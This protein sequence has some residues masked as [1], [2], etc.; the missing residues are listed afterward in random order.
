VEGTDFARLVGCF[1]R[2]FGS[3][4]PHDIPAASHDSVAGWDSIAQVTLLS[5]VGEEF[6]IEIDFEEFEEAT[7]FDAILEVVRARSGN[8]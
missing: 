2:V 3:L 8:G 5:L 4:N 1:Q 7:S 6:G